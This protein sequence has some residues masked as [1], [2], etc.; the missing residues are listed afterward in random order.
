MAVNSKHPLYS[1]N[2]E[3]WIKCQDCYDGEDAV[4]SKG[5]LY[6]PLTGGM[7]ED[8]GRNPNTPGWNAYQA[9]KARAVFHEF[10]TEAV[11]TFMGMM[12]NKPP[13]IELPKALE[14]MRDRATVSGET[15]E[16][17]LRRINEQQLVKGRLGLMADFPAKPT[18]DQVTPYLAVYDTEHI[19]NWDDTERDKI[20]F[21]RLNLVVLD[22]TAEERQTDFQWKRVEKYRVLSLGKPGEEQVEGV[23]RTY[24][25][26][27]MM[28]SSYDATA[29]LEP[30]YKGRKLNE[31]PFVMIN[32][33]DIVARPDDPPL[34]GLANLSLAIYRGE[35]DYR[36]ALFMQG[37]DTLVV[38]GGDKDA[39]YRIGAGA[40]IN[41][42]AIPGAKAEFIGCNSDGLPE[43]RS[44]LENDRNLAAQKAGKLADMKSA[45]RQSGEALKT[46]L[47]AQTATLNQV[48]LA[49][50][51]GLE[52]ILKTCARW[53]G[54]NEDEVKVVPNLE[55]DTIMMTAQE[56][57]QMVSAKTMGAPISTETIH[58]N[59]VARGMTK[60]TYEEEM[61]AINEEEPLVMGGPGAITDPDDPDYNKNKDPNYD[62]EKDPE[63]S[64][65]KDPDEDLARQKELIKAKQPP[66]KAKK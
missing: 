40:T 18:T 16:Q 39:V 8:G 45:Q 23:E 61:E 44:A 48:A 37:Q 35:A 46:R 56:L 11:E 34:L 43:M 15:L 25:A 30:S 32:A 6:L 13:V 22:E 65:F 66:K 49:G 50:A 26:G 52:A 62:P 20:G 58:D 10:F 54:A 24:W 55:F 29:M 2:L 38:V 3:A 42:K 60:K 63:S 31:L 59:M 41:L 33:K 47:G 57:V 9:Y 5:E 36:Q 64:R 27:L 19:I 7:I 4:K 12:W 53:V 28:S 17:L 51:A 1:E 21:D 14:P